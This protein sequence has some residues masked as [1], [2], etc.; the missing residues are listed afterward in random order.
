MMNILIQKD[1]V[2]GINARNLQYMRTSNAKES[3]RIADSKLRTK[4]VLRKQGIATVQTYKVIRSTKAL[5]ELDWD[6]LP[7]SFVLKPNKGFGGD[8]IV[9]VFG[10][11]KRKSP[12]EERKWITANGKLWDKSDFSTHIVN[13][14]DGSF[15]LHNNPDIA[16]IE[17]RLKNTPF[18]KPYTYKG[19]PDIRVVVYN[20]IPVMAMLRLPTSVSGGKAN[21]H[22]SGIGVGIDIATGVTTHAIQNDRE[23]DVHPDTKRILSG[24]KIPFWTKILRTAVSALQASGLGYGGVDVAIDRDLGPVVLELN[25]RPGLAIQIANQEGLAA[26]LKRV[27]GLKVQTIDKGIRIAKELFGGEIEE[28]IE[29]I[30]GRQVLGII[31]SVSIKGKNEKEIG[32]KAKIDTGAKST[33]LDKEVAK[34]AGY[35]E[36]ID[37]F[38]TFNVPLDL[39][40]QKAQEFCDTHREE[41]LKNKDILA[42]AVV[43]SSHGTTVRPIINVTLTISGRIVESKA[44][45]VSRGK[46]AYPIIIGR[47]DLGQFLVDPSKNKI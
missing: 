21:L 7:S 6:S 26:R 45:V 9:I 23:I 27:K 40:P 30:S 5:S 38:D 18:F 16:I 33:S 8:G 41:I 1:N 37:Y 3:V 31:E 44:N 17:Q 22:A 46:L 29:E 14:L 11:K 32:L 47:A 34:K 2:L 43:K 12:E 28:E 35:K 39:T 15:S 24:I 25:A 4:S 13:I 36:V 10:E 20:K 19:I 42:L